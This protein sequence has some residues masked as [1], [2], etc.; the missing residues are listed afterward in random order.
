MDCRGKGG[1]QMNFEI[2]PGS[3]VR[4]S[5]IGQ[6]PASRIEYRSATGPLIA[7]GITLCDEST[8]IQGDGRIE[9]RRRGDFGERED[10]R[11]GSWTIHMRSVTK[12]ESLWHRL[13]YAWT[14]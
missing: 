13:G 6:R 10:F 8:V 4:G 14:G 2:S 9:F 1:S 3:L 5:R 11:P 7:P 12:S